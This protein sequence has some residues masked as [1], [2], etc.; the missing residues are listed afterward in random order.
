M[1]AC[2]RCATEIRLD[3]VGARDVCSKCHAWLHCCRNCEFYS[4]GAHNDCHEPNAEVVADK[5]NGNFCDFFRLGSV[6][7]AGAGKS[8]DARAK[9][10]R[11]FGKK[12]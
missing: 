3:R 5:E 8:D 2:Y 1:T 6:A 9:L 10:E 4:P 11:L 12:S 7:A